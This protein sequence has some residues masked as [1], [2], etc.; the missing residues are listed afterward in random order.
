MYITWEVYHICIFNVF[1]GTLIREPYLTLFYANCINC[2]H[3]S[4]RIMKQLQHYTYRTEYISVGTIEVNY[5]CIRWVAGAVGF[6][7]RVLILPRLCRQQ[8]QSQAIILPGLSFLFFRNRKNPF[9][10]RSAALVAQLPSGKK[11]IVLYDS[12]NN[13]ESSTLMQRI[14]YWINYNT[15]FQRICYTFRHESNRTMNS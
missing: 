14:T 9:G 5:H 3:F 1:Y 11:C 13:K 15:Q 12:M 8:C 7:W 10:K 2:Y 4:Y 6:L